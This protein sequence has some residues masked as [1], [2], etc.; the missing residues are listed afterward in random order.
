MDSLPP[1]VDV[2]DGVGGDNVFPRSGNISVD[3][4]RDD[5]KKDVV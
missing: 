2:L 1:A 3:G 5:T 4:T